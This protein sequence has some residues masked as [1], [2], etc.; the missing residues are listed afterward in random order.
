MAPILSGGGYSSEAWSYVEALDASKSVPRLRILQHG[1]LEN[2]AFWTGLPDDMKALA[3]KLYGGDFQLNET[4]VICHS[5]PGAWYPPLFETTPCP[6]NGYNEPF[7]VIGRTMFETDRV[8][9]EHVRRCNKMDSVWVPTDF[10]VQTFIKSGVDSSKVVKIVQAVDVDFFNP[11]RWKPLPLPAD[12]RLFGPK[13]SKEVK[14]LPKSAFVFISIF[15][16]EWRKGWDVLLKA[17]LQEFSADDNVVL[18]ILTKPYHSDRAFDD[19]LKDFVKSSGLQEPSRGWAAVYLS[20][21]HVPQRE[22]PR[23][24]KAASAFVLPSRGEGWGRPH[25]E[26]MAMSLPVIATNWS[27]PTEYMTDYNSYPLPLDGMSEVK[28][29][30][31]KGHFWAEPSSSQLRLI[32]RHV[33]SSPVEAKLKGIQAR[34]DMVSKFSPAVVVKQVLHQL[35]QIHN[36]DQEST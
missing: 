2:L 28:E 30:P 17:Y 13:H 15:K 36:L 27:G 20:D 16:W 18:Y 23:L 29:G 19:K 24:Y 32:L 21:A 12:G 10:H 31:F 5:E 3:M 9:D 1:D 33:F 26:A 11:E 34:L 8:S 14:F 35:L 4:V 22:L 25:V 6:P 7:H